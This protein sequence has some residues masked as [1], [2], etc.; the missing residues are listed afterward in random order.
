MGRINLHQRLTWRKSRSTGSGEPIEVESSESTASLGDLVRVLV[1]AAGESDEALRRYLQIFGLA[2]STIR[3]VLVAMLAGSLIFG[4]GIAAVVA[5]L[6]MHIAVAFTIGAG[7]SASFILTAVA[8][9]RRG[10]K[11]ALSAFA[12]TDRPGSENGPETPGSENRR[13]AAK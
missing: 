4:A 8:R 11:A 3:E 7:G 2:R 9:T 6:G 13:T 5:G 12:A 1:S 10:I